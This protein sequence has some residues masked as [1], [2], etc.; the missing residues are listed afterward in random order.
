M[1]PRVS[2]AEIHQEFR[3]RWEVQPAGRG[4]GAGCACACSA[5]TQGCAAAEKPQVCILIGPPE[6]SPQV[7][8]TPCAPPPLTQHLHMAPGVLDTRGGQCWPPGRD[9]SSQLTQRRGTH[10]GNLN[11]NRHSNHRFP[12]HEC[13]L[14]DRLN[15]NST[16]TT[17]NCRPPMQNHIQPPS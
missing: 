4:P 6:P 11:Q 3:E 5:W 1:A 8:V 7:R 12:F 10:P 16:H 15:R 9:C 14:K 2:T 13:F 17:D